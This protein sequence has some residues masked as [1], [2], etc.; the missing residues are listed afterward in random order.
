MIALSVE[1]RATAQDTAPTPEQVRFFETSIRPVLV[2]HCWDCHGAKK[3]WA[4]LRLDS[5]KGLLRGGDLGA[6]VVPGRAAD[7]RLIRAIKHEDESL[8]MPENGKLS[9]RQI[10]DFVKWVEDGAPFPES[11]PGGAKVD[12]AK[13]WAFQPIT[14]PTVPQPDVAPL[15]AFVFAKQ[16]AAGVRSINAADKRTLIRRATSDLT[17]LPP[18][19]HEIDA[20]LKDE[21]TES[22]SRLI[23]R[24]LASAAYGERWGR[25]WLDVA[26][27]ADTAGDGADYP[28]REAFKYRDWVV[29]SFNADQP[30]DEFIREQIAGDI[31][32]RTGPA[33]Q[34]ASRVTATGFL[35][36]GKR[37][38]YAPNPD[39]QHLDFADAIDSIGRSVL[40]LSLGCARCHD[41]KYDPVTMQDYYGLYGILK[42]TQWAFPGGEEQK[43]PAFFPPLVPPAEAARRDQIKAAELARL[44]G[45]LAHL[46]NDRAALNGNAFAG[47]IDLGFESQTLGKPPE[48]T[49]LALGPN[50]V[51]AE[52]QSPFA[53]TH[54]VGSRGVRM[55]TGL[56][57]D[58]V[59]YVFNPGVRAIA[60]KQMH[61]TIDFR[62]VAP[63]KQTGAFRFYL[64]R[65]VIGSTA[66]DISVTANELAIRSGGAWSVVRRI[67]PGAW[68]TLRLTLDRDRKSYSGL[69][70]NPN[71]LTTISDRPLSASWDGVF[72]TFICDGTGHAE[73]PSPVRDLDNIGLQMTPFGEP[74]SGPVVAPKTPA[75][76]PQQI[77][78][79]DADIAAMTKQR[80]AENAKRL[81]PVDYGV[82]EGTPTNVR[83][84]KRGEP[85]KLGDEAARGFVAVLGDARLPPEVK[86]SG[87]LELANWLTRPTNPLTAR[88]FVNRVWQ[89]H[90]GQGLVPTPSDFGTRGDAPTHP[91]LLD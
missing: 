46:K 43:R 31:L 25:H 60:G 52:A 39:Y 72:D 56:K 82:T 85:D 24:L 9:E 28:V 77:A 38:G 8:K 81:Y 32:A 57:T 15:D 3:Q 83:I 50:T 75:D 48:G 19:P 49:W 84:Q 36:V 51:V 62:V 5:R 26:R 80:D 70:G 88:V 40:G 89:W 61:F 65:G 74:G 34:Y 78:K 67:E 64:G 41:H 79:L 30:F 47:G 20:F 69:V 12:P 4:G 14:R 1:V 54:P 73:G 33:E 44:D 27:Y 45:E 22:F 2:E 6:A 86:G 76:L 71:D 63:V 87:R 68:Y 58:G 59:R 53:H 29:N 35:A 11:Q 90:F 55:G 37:Y 7:S 66:V 21:S 42:S 23:D 13:H 91:E 10:A 17:G 16:R 18:T